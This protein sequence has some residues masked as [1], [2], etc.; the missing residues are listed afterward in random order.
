MRETEKKIKTQLVQRH[1]KP[2]IPAI[3]INL[4]NALEVRAVKQAIDKL[5]GHHGFSTPDCIMV[6]DSLLTTHLGKESTRLTTI[7]EQDSF[8]DLML[9]SIEKVKCAIIELFLKEERP[10]LMG[11]LPDGTSASKQ[12]LINIS[13]KML[14]HG[15]DIVKLEIISKSDLTLIEFLVENNIPVAAHIGYAPQKNNNR[16]YGQTL[17]EALEL[18]EIVRLAGDCGASVIILERIDEVI[19]Q[20]LCAPSKSGLP[21]FSIFSGKAA[22][23]GQS[24]NIWDSVYKPG[25]Q[26]H[27]FPPTSRYSPDTYPDSYT[28]NTIANCFYNLLK[29]TLDREFPKSPSTSL[30]LEDIEYLKSI[31]PWT[32]KII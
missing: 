1:Q 6:G 17:Q 29:L 22:G 30:S 9:E 2:D 15:A 13:G 20:I 26:S 24:L 8:V 32:N 18:I 7:E 11:D 4:Y 23:G 10:Y 12:R 5:K 19:N 31:G 21:I 25:F 16:K 3:K 27:F 14:D 28:Q